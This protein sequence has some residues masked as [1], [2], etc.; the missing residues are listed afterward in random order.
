LREGITEGI[1]TTN[2]R[3]DGCEEDISKTIHTVIR[4]DVWKRQAMRGRYET[5]QFGG[6]KDEVDDSECHMNVKVKD[7]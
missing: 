3:R 4:Q 2:S 1:G 5:I 7:Q 6:C